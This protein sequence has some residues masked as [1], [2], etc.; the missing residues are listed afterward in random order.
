MTHTLKTAAL[1]L[2]VAAGIASIAALLM[3]APAVS[4]MQT[5]SMTRI[6]AIPA[7]A[8]QVDEIV[9]LAFGGE[10]DYTT[11]DAIHVHEVADRVCEGFTAGVPIIEMDRIL[12]EQENLTPVAAHEFVLGVHRIQCPLN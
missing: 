1:L 8:P 11:L 4:A 12:V 9:A 3:P 10:T 5:V 2:L 6:D 7:P